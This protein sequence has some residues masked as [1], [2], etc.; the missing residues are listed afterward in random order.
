MISLQSW[1]PTSRTPALTAV[2]FLS[3][4]LNQ[5]VSFAV[6]ASGKYHFRRIAL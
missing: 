3:P 5:T 6:G 1:N 4:R 2:K